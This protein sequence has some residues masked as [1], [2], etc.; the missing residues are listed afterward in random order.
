MLFNNSSF[1]KLGP[2]G[3]LPAGDSGSLGPSLIPRSRILTADLENTSRILAAL[4]K[5]KPGETILSLYTN[6]STDLASVAQLYDDLERAYIYLELIKIDQG[7]KHKLT[8][9]LDPEKHKEETLARVKEFRSDLAKLRRQIFTT[10]NQALR[11]IDKTPVEENGYF[12]ADGLDQMKESFRGFSDQLGEF[13]ERIIN[14]PRSSKEKAR[15][16]AADGHSEVA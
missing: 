15:T 14:L 9:I 12:S 2:A 4:A 7:Q 11:F 5:P 6:V 3:M 16:L 13:L 8:T 1:S 10:I